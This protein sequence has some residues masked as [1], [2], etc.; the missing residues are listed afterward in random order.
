MHLSLFTAATVSSDSIIKRPTVLI[1]AGKLLSELSNWSMTKTPSKA[2]ALRHKDNSQVSLKHGVTLSD[3]AC[4]HAVKNGFSPRRMLS[5]RCLL[6][7]IAH[8]RQLRTAGNFAG[9]DLLC[10][11]SELDCTNATLMSMNPPRTQVCEKQ[12]QSKR[13]C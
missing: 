9:Q 5:V 7:L 13:T 8:S 6:Q 12:Q 11:M 10:M 3:A 2:T 1:S 4:C